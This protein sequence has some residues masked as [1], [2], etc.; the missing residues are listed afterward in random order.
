MQGETTLRRRGGATSPTDDRS[1]TTEVTTDTAADAP[2]PSST[3]TSP[4]ARS[5]KTVPELLAD[6]SKSHANFLSLATLVVA[7]FLYMMQT[8]HLPPSGRVY[9]VMIDAGSTGT[10][11]QV[12]A[13]RLLKGQKG[14]VLDDSEVFKMGKSIAALGTG[15]VGDGATFFKP[16]F[17]K[18]RK[19]V[20][21]VRRRLRTP[22]AL[23]ATAGLRLIGEEHAEVA[24]S[25]ARKA[26]NKSGFLF[27]E[28]WVSILEEQEEASHAWT[29]VNFLKGHFHGNSEE[30]KYAGALDLG[31]ASMQV[32]FE[33][34]NGDE[35]TD[36]GMEGDSST[37]EADDD[38]ADD[39]D[40]SDANEALIEE[41][42][43]TVNVFGNSYS[44]HSTS[45]L[46]LGLFDF[47]KKLYTLFDREGVL[48]EGNPCFRKGKV[49]SNKKLRFGVPGSEESRTITM[50]GDGNFERCVASAEITIATFSRLG[51][52]KS[53]LP[54]GKP[55]YAFAY[56]YDRTVRLG[57]PITP[58]KAQLVA[59][60]KELCETPPD[61]HL[62]RDFD[63]ACAEFSYVYTLLKIFTNDFASKDVQIRFEQ[64]IDG[65]MLGWA[66]G[67]ALDILQ[68]VMQKQ[69]ALEHEPLI[70]V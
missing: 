20:P 56:F 16:L 40:A 23:R 63:Q 69:L 44:L 13:F 4:P 18:L 51:K 55:F 45:H 2:A 70:A 39:E 1:T 66:L 67:A 30:I 15:T 38:V 11:A 42:D 27:Q 14:L 43:H 35:S 62:E 22:I 37:D 46:G 29:T 61:Q 53:T 7:F 32:V 17:E 36:V 19:K 26:L 58:T 50:T 25:E 3:D 68:P 31:G 33:R 52:M 24:L 8:T 28:D 34:E 21:G 59:K 12:F 47:T 65:H 60:G 48:E 6:E 54:K 10:R 64:F 9:S 41:S 49:F 5:T 57:L